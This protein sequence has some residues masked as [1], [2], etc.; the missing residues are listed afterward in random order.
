MQTSRCHCELAQN[1]CELTVLQNPL[2]KDQAH[3]F[4]HNIGD[5]ISVYLHGDSHHHAAVPDWQGEDAAAVPKAVVP[6]GHP[7][8]RGGG[9]RV[10]RQY[11]QAHDNVISD[12]KSAGGRPWL[13]LELSGEELAHQGVLR[14]EGRRHRVPGDDVPGP[15]R[16]RRG[17]ADPMAQHQTFQAR[18]AVERGVFPGVLRMDG[19]GG[20]GLPLSP[21]R[22]GKA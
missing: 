22:G 21:E 4:D 19:R 10:C 8:G 16:F 17:A 3:V 20:Q 5:H 18:R 1:R 15:R 14:A 9:H 7:G 12:G 11:A 13:G 2:R 6:P